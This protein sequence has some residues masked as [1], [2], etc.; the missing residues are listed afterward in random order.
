M[1]PD[2]RVVDEISYRE[3]LC[4][5]RN[6]ITLSRNFV[7]QT[8][9]VDEI[10]YREISR[11][12]WTLSRNFA[13]FREISRYFDEISCRKDEVSWIPVVP[14]ATFR[15]HPIANTRFRGYFWFFVNFCNY[16]KMCKYWYNLKRCF[17]PWRSELSVST[18]ELSYYWR[19]SSASVIA[20]GDHYRA[21][22]NVVPAEKFWRWKLSKSAA[23]CSPVLTVELPELSLIYC[24]KQ[25]RKI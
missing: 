10:S 23:L 6:F 3:V 7:S 17:A 2:Y 1:K 18:V 13:K 16:T 9:V 12:N 5:L 15:N 14:V 24:V 21:H 8:R 22:A 19:L 4:I 25:N 11:N 20:L